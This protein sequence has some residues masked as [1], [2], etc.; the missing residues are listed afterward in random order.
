[1]KF[2]WYLSIAHALYIGALNFDEL[3][4]LRKS[5]KDSKRY[6]K[7]LKKHPNHLEL[8]EKQR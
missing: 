7:Y 5:Y 1:M 3:K 2:M 4:H 6:K 8:V